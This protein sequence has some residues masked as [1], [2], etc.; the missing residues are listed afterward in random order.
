LLSAARG[1]VQMVFVRLLLQTDQADVL[2]NPHPL[3]GLTP[4]LQKLPETG[5]LSIHEVFCPSGAHELGM[6]RPVPQLFV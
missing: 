6:G 5:I 4:L 3:E 1:D 2:L